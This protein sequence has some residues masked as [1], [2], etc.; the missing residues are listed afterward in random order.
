[1]GTYT[2]IVISATVKR[3]PH[4]EVLSYMLGLRDN[5][6]DLPDYP[7]FK[8]SRWHIML[9]SCSYYFVPETVS[10]LKYDDI[11]K[12]WSLIVRSDFKNYG[13]EIYDFFNW[14]KDKWA[15]TNTMVG[16]S[17]CE[18][19]RKPTIYYSLENHNND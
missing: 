5:P 7:L 4:I 9:R 1:M 11:A 8:T 14:M 6:P 13:G 19:D 16:Y 10:L 3:G 15:D 18:E 2:E 12:E 17:R